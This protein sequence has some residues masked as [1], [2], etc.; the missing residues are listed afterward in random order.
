MS[1]YSYKNSLVPEKLFLNQTPLFFLFFSLKT[2]HSI[3]YFRCQIVAAK[4]PAPRFDL[5][6]PTRKEHQ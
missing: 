3:F 2:Y 4:I 5:A 1:F 6:E